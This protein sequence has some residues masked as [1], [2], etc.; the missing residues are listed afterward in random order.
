MNKDQLE[1]INSQNDNRG[2]VVVSCFDGM[3]CAYLALKELGIKVYKYFVYE[4]DKFAIKQTQHNIKEVI[5]LGDIQKGSVKDF[6]DL[7]VDLICGGSP[8]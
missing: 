6:G 4:I 7:Q 8:C 1:I 2:I 5:H 3:G